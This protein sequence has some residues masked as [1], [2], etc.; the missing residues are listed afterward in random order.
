MSSLQDYLAKNYGSLDDAKKSKKKDRRKKS[1]TPASTYGAN[2]IIADDD[3][4]DINNPSSI[5]EMSIP[6][7]SSKPSTRKKKS[8]KHSETTWSPAEHVAEDDEHPV[9]AEGAELIAEYNLRRQQEAAAAEAE[10]Q[11]LRE[12]RRSQARQTEEE[13]EVAASR[14]HNADSPAP[15][16][17]SPPPMR[18]GLLTAQAVKE[19]SER[20]RQRHLHKLQNASPETS[21]RDA[22]TV[23]RDAKT[24]KR[25]DIA[26]EA[27]REE[28]NRRKEEEMRRLQREWNKGLVHQRTGVVMSEAELDAERR[29]KQHWNDPARRFLENKTTEKSRFPEYKGDAPPN[30]FGIRPGYRWDGVDRSN[31]FEAEYFR[32]Q[33]AASSRKAE[34]YAYSVADL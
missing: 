4:D 10:N 12:L 27:A 1:H 29:A 13:A 31:G 3:I 20:T 18:Y 24:G 6:T 8:K 34:S 23:Y 21:G 16:D 17:D 30:R 7:I 33:A 2:V 28:E 15:D 14:S 22:E 5:H 9:V 26:Q 25:I 19:D 32:N 11:R